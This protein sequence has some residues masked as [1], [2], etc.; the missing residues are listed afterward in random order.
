VRDLSVEFRS[1]DQT[2]RPVDSVSYEL[3]PGETLGIVGES[4]S[5][6]TTSVLALLGLLPELR[7]LHITGDA[8]L[9][10]RDLLHMSSRLRRRMLGAQVGVI[11][12]DPLTSLNPVLTV[13]RQITEVIEAHTQVNHREAQR[14]AIELLELVGIPQPDARVRQYPHELSGGLR[15]RVMIASS[16]A[17]RPSLLI[18][19]EATTALDVTIQAQVIEVFRQAKT[20]I[21]AA[22]IVISHD[23]GV[24]AELADH[25]LVMY[26][27]RVIESGPVDL[28]FNA[29]RHPYTSALLACR[30]RL[31]ARAERLASI[32]GRPPEL[33][34]IPSG[35]PFHPR[36]PLGADKEICA[37]ETPQLRTMGDGH[38]AACHFAEE[39]IRLDH[40]NGN[41]DAAVAK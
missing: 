19:D 23:L 41:R 2:V 39:V 37:E 18:A 15:Q 40:A 12:Q 5:G 20:E 35:C 10:G 9:S 7:D 14:R 3:R 28:I 38:H 25:V 24:I 17:N 11:F 27:G 34:A 32:P 8:Q 33:T 21:G 30:P 29:P 31:E 4:G 16:I 13:G 26:A 6:K 36:C 1:Q 22:A